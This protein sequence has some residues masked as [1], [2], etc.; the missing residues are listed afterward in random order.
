MIACCRAQIVA[1]K[2]VRRARVSIS[3]AAA[4]AAAA[5]PPQNHLGA[6]LRVRATTT[7]F[8]A[9]SRELFTKP[10]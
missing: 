8:K 1:S 6:I 10:A 5:A 2:S 9:T 4:A 3:T 7:R